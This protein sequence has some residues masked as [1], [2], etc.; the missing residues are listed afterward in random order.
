MMTNDLDAYYTNTQ[1]KDLV[2]GNIKEHFQKF[3]KAPEVEVI[4][5]QNIQN[6]YT[7]KLSC[8]LMVTPEIILW[9]LECFCQIQ[10]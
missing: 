9:L 1:A 10:L 7:L 2:T 6:F 4:S 5:F 3:E 8:S